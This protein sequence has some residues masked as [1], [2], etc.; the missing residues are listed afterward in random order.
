MQEN[1]AGPLVSPFDGPIVRLLELD[2]NYCCHCGESKVFLGGRICCSVGK[3]VRD[4]VATIC[5]ILSNSNCLV[6][7]VGGGRAPVVFGSTR[8]VYI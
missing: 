8:R 2:P 5:E 3:S 1:I 7:L 6:E 4:K